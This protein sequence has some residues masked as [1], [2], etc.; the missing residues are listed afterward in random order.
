MVIP[1]RIKTREGGIPLQAKTA[2]DVMSPA[3]VTVTSQDELFK[4]ATLMKEHEIGFIPVVDQN[5]PIGVIT[6][7]DIV[8]RGLAEKLPG[9]TKVEQ[10]MSKTCIT[11]PPTGTLSDAAETMAKNKIR[12]VLVVEGTNL[13]G[14]VAIGDL[15]VR[16]ASNARAGKALTEISSH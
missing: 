7:R 8:T 6:D 16:E 14:V 12:R 3:P 5:K 11:I 4:V 13:L 2:K 15:A 9:S 1:N 10:V